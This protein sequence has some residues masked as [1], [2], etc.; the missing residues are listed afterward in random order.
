MGYSE[1]K[2]RGLFYAYAN[3]M[4][5]LY[6][7]KKEPEIY[8]YQHFSMNRFL[9]DLKDNYD[10]SLSLEKNLSLLGIKHRNEILDF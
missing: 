4:K 9:I 8:L 6:A 10:Q 7:D 1:L 3:E 5:N 2:P